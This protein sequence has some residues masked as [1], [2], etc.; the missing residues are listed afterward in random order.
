[1]KRQEII[2][3]LS[4]SQWA[5]DNVHPGTTVE[6]LAEW[7]ADQPSAERL[8][9]Q[10]AEIMAAAERDPLIKA[11]YETPLDVWGKELLAQSRQQ[12][13][14]APVEL[15]PELLRFEAVMRDTWEEPATVIQYVKPPDELEALSVRET[16]KILHVSRSA[17]KAL[18]SD[19]Q[20]AAFR[21]G[22]GKH[23]KITRAAIS[24]FQEQNRVVPLGKV[25][26]RWKRDYFPEAE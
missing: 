1:M 18:I 12:V 24:A 25:R 11:M 5:K 8:A 13:A 3:V 2:D 21:I 14:I 9:K 6:E 22:D 23:Q 4:R 16:A 10:E 20:L 7:R 17:V 15:L 26:G 19:G